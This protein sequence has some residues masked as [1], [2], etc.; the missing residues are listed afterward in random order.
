MSYI[1]KRFWKRIWMMGVLL[2]LIPSTGPAAVIKNVHFADTVMVDQTELKVRG[3]AVL[4]WG[5]LFNVYAGAFYLPG[6]NSGR[7]WK[8][9][10][11]KRLELAYFREIKATDFADSSDQ[12]LRRNL[13]TAEY[14]ALE[15]RL[16]KF[17]TL[18][19]DVQPGDRYRLTYSPGL[20]TEL[21]LNDEP[22]GVVPGADFSVAYFGI[23]LGENPISE[24]FRDRLL[25]Y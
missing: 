22:L 17:W 10:I 4:K 19:R 7:A 13:S 23:W 18:F 21:R 3:V 2:L 12:L 14:Q 5:L 1:V 6:G 16:K 20:G 8:S 25:R 9:D 24:K 15:E 11:P